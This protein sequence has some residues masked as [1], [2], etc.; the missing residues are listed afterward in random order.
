MPFNKLEEVD[1]LDGL[2]EEYEDF[3][4]LGELDI[5]EV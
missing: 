2:I 3:E 4:E 1:V 5:T